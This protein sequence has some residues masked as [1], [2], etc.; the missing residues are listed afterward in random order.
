MKMHRRSILKKGK[1]LVEHMLLVLFH[2]L[3]KVSHRLSYH[4]R[5][6]E[7]F[8]SVTS[9]SYIDLLCMYWYTTTIFFL[10]TVILIY[11]IYSRFF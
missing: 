9:I 2:P 7:D 3:Q 6:A 5:I 1:A 10:V 8:L 4:I 11:S